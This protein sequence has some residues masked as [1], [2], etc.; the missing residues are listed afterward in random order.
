MAEFLPDDARLSRAQSG[1]WPLGLFCIVIGAA[2]L[3]FGANYDFGTVI[4]MGPG[5]VPRL[6]AG[7]LILIGVLIIADGGRDVRGEAALP[8]IH[9]R[10]FA[11]IALCIIG[12]IIIFGLTLGPLGLAVATFLMVAVAML[13]Q[14]GVHPAT[15]VITAVVLSIF[16]VVLFPVLLGI[17]IPVLPQGIR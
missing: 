7:G 16:A 15:V 12:S 9:F 6:I 10:S 3:W 13:A 1:H 4:S 5:F 8:P 14:R 17:S 2:A 11:R